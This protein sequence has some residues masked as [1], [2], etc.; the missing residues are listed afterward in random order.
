MSLPTQQLAGLSCAD[1]SQS[2][3]L[4]NTAGYAQDLFMSSRENC[5]RFFETRLSRKESWAV[6]IMK[7]KVEVQKSIYG[8]PGIVSSFSM[9][10]KMLVSASE[11]VILAAIRSCR[12]LGGGG[13]TSKAKPANSTS[14]KP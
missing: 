8:L 11:N 5:M 9:D 14:N 6:K 1:T 13:C 12:L 2:N 4:R 10:T 3:H 7:H